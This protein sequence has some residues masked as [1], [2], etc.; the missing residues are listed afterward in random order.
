MWFY[1]INFFLF[2]QSFFFLLNKLSPHKTF[3]LESMFVTWKML[4]ISIFRKNINFAFA[5]HWLMGL[6]LKKTFFFIEVK[7]RVYSLIQFDFLIMLIYCRGISF[8][9]L[10]VR[11]WYFVLDLVF[12]LLPFK[13]ENT[14]KL[15]T[16]KTPVRSK[17]L[18]S[19]SL[20]LVAN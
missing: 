12:E 11:F 19:I 3:A 2:V 20:N 8:R 13:H 6:T 7:M 14:N 5:K 16:T 18:V 15:I 1:Y 4:L 9:I 10:W 17:A